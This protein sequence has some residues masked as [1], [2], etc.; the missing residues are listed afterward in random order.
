VIS[1]PRN[2]PLP[3]PPSSSV[4]PYELTFGTVCGV[5]AGVFIK[6]GARALAFVLGG[7]FV[8]LQVCG[9]VSVLCYKGL[10]LTNF[11]STLALEG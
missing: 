2:D 3:P 6:K 8:L 9:L 5:C 10:T 1:T 4:R 11:L 7:V